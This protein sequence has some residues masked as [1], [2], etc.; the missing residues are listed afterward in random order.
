M[1]VPTLSY[2]EALEAMKRKRGDVSTSMNAFYSS[3]LGG[4]VTDPAAMQV[5]FVRLATTAR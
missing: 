5:P 2:E 4:I 1:Y 3:A